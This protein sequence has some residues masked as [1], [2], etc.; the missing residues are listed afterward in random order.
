MEPISRAVADPVPPDGRVLVFRALPGIG[1]LLCAVPAL[2]ALRASR[3]D[4][5]IAYVGLPETE[6]LVERFPRYVDRFIAFPGFPGLPDR[7]P[8]VRKLPELLA[9]VQA[10]R[11]DLAVQLHG[12]GELTNPITALFG[13]RR[14][15][16]H[17]RTRPP[18]DAACFLPWVEGCSE[19]RRG[20]RLMAHLGWP[21]DDETLEFPIAPGA[22]EALLALDGASAIATRPIVVVHPGAS[23]ASRRWSPAGFAEV[24]DELADAGYLVVLSGGAAERELTAVVASLMRNPAIDLA[25]RTTL[26]LLAALVRRAS[27]LVCNDTGVSHLAAAL[28]TP[29]VV[30]FR[31][32]D[33]H[34]WAP[35][36]QRLHRPVFGSSRQVLSEARR[37]LRAGA[38]RHAA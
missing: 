1:D 4:V 31:T 7:R 9:T 27:L 36:D 37:A 28:A 26:D 18:V 33:K 2:R 23:E 19:V 14:M 10:E 20:L 12:S 6:A 5:E 17:Y 21:S 22:D 29:S 35:L 13:A 34:R 16:G 24:A 3:P 25:G 32:S 11:F 8:D 38:Q 30:V 15:A